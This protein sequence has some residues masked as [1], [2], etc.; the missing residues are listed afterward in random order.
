MPLSSGYPAE[1]VALYGHILGW[2]VAEFPKTEPE[3]YA[4]YDHLFT[5][6]LMGGKDVEVSIHKIES[7]FRD[8]LASLSSE[9]WS[10]FVPSARRL[11]SAAKTSGC[12]AGV[13]YRGFQRPE[14]SARMYGSIDD[15]RG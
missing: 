3:L 11:G 8:R 5:E 1:L 7:A 2:P 14:T 6:E 4:L 9:Q 15:T 12:S 10:A 13:E